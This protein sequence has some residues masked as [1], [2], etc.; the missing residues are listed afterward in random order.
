MHHTV[1]IAPIHHVGYNVA[2]PFAPYIS[3]STIG[4][5]LVK[6]GNAIC[7]LQIASHPYTMLA[8]KPHARG[9]APGATYAL[10]S[11]YLIDYTRATLK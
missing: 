4:K 5:C 1:S 6:L 8:N 9:I 7:T 3:R 10:L 2:R 11:C